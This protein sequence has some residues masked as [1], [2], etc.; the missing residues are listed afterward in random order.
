MPRLYVLSGDDLGRTFDVDGPTVIGRGERAD[1]RVRDASVSREHAR[2]EPSE[3]PGG[4][5]QGWRVVDLGSRNGVFVD[6]ARV[7]EP[8][9]PKTPR[10]DTENY[11]TRFNG[12]TGS[13]L[14]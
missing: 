3:G 8:Q 10:I 12:R 5:A 7:R 11:L 14:G 9:N 2:L 13:A 1:V 4:T 6:G